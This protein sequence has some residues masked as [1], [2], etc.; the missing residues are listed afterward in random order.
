MDPDDIRVLNA[1]TAAGGASWLPA[2]PSYASM[3]ADALD[4]LG[5]PDLGGQSGAAPV[6]VNGSQAQPFASPV[7]LTDRPSLIDPSELDSSVPDPTL[8]QTYSVQPGDSPWRIAAQYV[9][10]GLYPD[11]WTGVGA[12]ARA[13]HLADALFPGRSLDIAAPQSGDA[14]LGGRTIAADAAARHASS[15]SQGIWLDGQYFPQDQMNAAALASLR[16]PPAPLAAA[17]NSSLDSYGFD[18]IRPHSAWDVWTQSFRDRYDDADR[19]LAEA[20]DLRAQRS[21]HNSPV[22]NLVLD[23]RAALA[24]AQGLG[25]GFWAPVSGVLDTALSLARTGNPEA[26]PVDRADVDMQTTLASLAATAFDPAL[27]ETE[28]IHTGPYGQLTQDLRG[29]GLQAHH[30][31]QNAA[32]ESVIPRPDGFSVG[33]KGD[34]LRDPGSPHYGFHEV[35]EDFWDRHRPGGDLF[36]Q[37]PT[38]A[39]YDDAMRQALRGAGFTR[40]EA[41]DLARQAAAQRAAYGLAPSDAVP[42]VPSR[43]PQKGR[44]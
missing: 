18:A 26:R 30:L 2:L 38:N 14:A 1:L 3:L 8:D 37:M 28:F 44:N 43:L 29:S 27:A 7:A 31:N 25:L 12:L 15:P 11:V 6:G 34:A 23:G 39:Q 40:G 16:N 41:T 17:P 42:R 10:S 4:S 21:P 22:E 35:L 5:S 9:K 32:Y 13:N 24:D 36:P 33:M 19:S 20:G